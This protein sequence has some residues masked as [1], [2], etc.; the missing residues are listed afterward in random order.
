[1]VRRVAFGLALCLFGAWNGAAQ[2]VQTDPLQCWWRTS[3][4]AV[5]VGEPFAVVL[6]CAV[7]ETDAATVVVDQSRLEP[8]VVQF[9]PF[10]VLG[11]SHGA[12]LRTDDRRF[13]Q[14]EYRLRL[15]AENEFGKDVALPETKLSY[16]VQSKVGQKTS[17]Q[18]RDQTYILPAQSV[19]VM[20]LVPVDTADIRDTSAETFTDIDA[21]AFRANLYTVI[22]GVMFVLAGLLALLVLVRL[23]GRFRKP[24]TVS[25]R[26]ITDGTILR[27]VGRELAAVRKERDAGGGWTP[28]LAGR[29]LA[30]LRIVATYAVG[31]RVG[32][33][34]A[35]KLTAEGLDAPEAGRLILRAGWPRGKRI[36]VSGAITSQTVAH[37]LARAT[38][39]A[40]RT[41]LLESLSRSLNTFTTAHFGREGALDEPA[42]DEALETAKQVLRRMKLEQF[43]IMKRLA[44]RRAGTEL[45]NRA[46][47]R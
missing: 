19:R 33:L 12:D 2:D 32:H 22:G 45:D 27:G 4:G 5:R 13:F 9:A 47:S 24:A 35:N 39:S 20:S 21:R 18:G 10:E 23:F 15:I 41:T 37:E 16:H 14:Y 3:A 26:L 44:A 31:R 29:A 8:S 7:L 25:D 34:P 1:M 28:D 42:L 46:W 43:W 11:G 36:A 30:A 17:L 38:S 6:T 40:R